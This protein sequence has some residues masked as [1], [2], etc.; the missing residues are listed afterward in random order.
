[1]WF[2][3][4]YEISLLCGELMQP[5]W[6]LLT[7]IQIFNHLNMYLATATHNSK[8]LK[9]TPISLIWER[10]FENFAV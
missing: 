9:I 1:M 4:N 10:A 5:A 8:W 2:R 7:L 6:T 3:L